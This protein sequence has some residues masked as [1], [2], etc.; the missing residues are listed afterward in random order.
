MGNI[1]AAGAA[2]AAS[3]SIPML[4]GFGTAGIAAGSSAAAIKSKI[5]QLLK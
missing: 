5:L 2:I 3:F 4:M 1:V